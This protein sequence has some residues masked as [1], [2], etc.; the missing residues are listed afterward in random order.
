[1]QFDH[2]SNTAVRRFQ[3][4][5]KEMKAIDALE[6]RSECALRHKGHLKVGVGLQETAHNGHAHGHIPHRGKSDHEDMTACGQW[7]QFFC[8]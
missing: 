5:R 4:C 3:I 2:P 1:M 8:R 7:N 6:H